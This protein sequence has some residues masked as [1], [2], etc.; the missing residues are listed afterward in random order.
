MDPKTKG[1]WLLHHAKKLQA[2]TNQDFDNIAFSGK[3]GTLLS[4]ISAEKENFITQT[5]LY[6]LARA[7]QI[8]PKTELPTIIEELKR[9]RLVSH[10][11]NGIV[12]LG[13]TGNKILEHTARIYSEGD[14]EPHEDAVLIASEISSE[15][16]TNS[17]EVATRIS[18]E[19]HI[20]IKD[21]NNTL[22]LGCEIGFFDSEQISPQEKL[23]FNGNLFRK[24]NAKKVKIVLDSLNQAEQTK[25]IDA[26][27]TLE[28]KG[29]IPLS[30]IM[31]ILG[32]EL[33]FKLH[34]IG[35]FDVNI[36]GNEQGRT[37]FVTRPAAFTKFNTSMEDDALDLAKA[38]VSSLTYGMT[39]STYYR[40]RIANISA[41]MNKLIAGK[42][43]GPATAIGNDYQALE[44]K[45]VIKVEPEE[46]GMFFMSLLKPDVGRLALSVIQNG[47][48][49]SE[50]ITNLPSAQITQYVD[51]ETNRTIQRKNSSEPVRLQTQRL[52]QDIRT[53]GMK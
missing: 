18:D 6:A 35:L 2:T 36:V 20:S 13:L 32:D 14:H 29:C 49:T 10:C 45:G 3:T 33:F 37:S 46:N 30:S 24:N 9:Q 48:I 8:S 38:L 27:K 25:L 7:S 47:D 16:P 53:G 4:A 19:L 41:L 43:V 11:D 52:L 51:P 21:T 50:S 26:N 42:K 12:T 34:S 31:T 17:N 44:L 5:R 39:L 28:E 23:L 1:A 22:N 15:M 40:G